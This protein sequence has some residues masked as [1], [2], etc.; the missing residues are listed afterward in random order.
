MV[1]EISIDKFANFGKFDESR[2]HD[3]YGTHITKG[4]KTTKPQ[5]E[6]RSLISPP[7][8]CLPLLFPPAYWL[9]AR[10]LTCLA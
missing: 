4:E 10:A 8:P 1:G 6:G 2:D 3:L 9:A 7:H 5:D